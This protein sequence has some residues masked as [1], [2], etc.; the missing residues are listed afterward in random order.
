MNKTKN[1]RER[2]LHYSLLRN[3]ADIYPTVDTITIRYK[4]VYRS[5]F[6]TSE[7]EHELKYTSNNRN[8]FLIKCLN[9][10]CTS[11]GY[12]LEDIIRNMVYYCESYKEDN[13]SCSG[14]EAP[15][16]LYQRCGSSLPYSIQITYKN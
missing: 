12:D 15:D 14:I 3:I 11:I 6:G 16:H 8:N 10:E 13:I 4:Q 2:S 7:D 9:R 5:A 1:R